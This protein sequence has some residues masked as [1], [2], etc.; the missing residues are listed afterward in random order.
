MCQVA[1]LE[2][3]IAAVSVG[4]N[5]R[6]LLVSGYGL[7]PW[8][9]CA[10]SEPRLPHTLLSSL[11]TLL[12]ALLHQ[13]SASL[14]VPLLCML[15]WHQPELS[16]PQLT[17][18]LAALSPY[19]LPRRTVAHLVDVV[20]ST[21]GGVLPLRTM[22]T[23]GITCLDSYHKEQSDV[24]EYLKQIIHTSLNKNKNC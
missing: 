7:C 23:E 12:C 19:S 15:T 8:L 18:V 5:A 17:T 24:R 3:L 11:L 9:Y 1:I 21:V 10:I 14:L 6:Q 16:V 22:L 2:V 20:D 4:H 13:S